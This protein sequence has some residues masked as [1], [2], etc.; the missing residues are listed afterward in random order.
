MGLKHVAIFFVV[1]I[2]LLSGNI[3]AGGADMTVQNE[4]EVAFDYT[5]KVDGQVVD[6]S[7]GKEPFQYKHGEG[8][9]LPELSSQLEGMKEGDEKDVTLEPK[10]AYGEVNSGAFKEIQKTELPKDVD[11][12]VDMMLQ[13]AT[14][15]GR[16]LPVRISEVK[17]EAIVIDLNHPL[18]GKTL[19]FNIKIVSVK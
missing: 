17:D 4:A 15:D 7:E 16:A 6:S 13:M 8:R 2:S 10:D 11:P 3:I 19:N 1:I 12:Q 9:I 18:A 14:P 5:L